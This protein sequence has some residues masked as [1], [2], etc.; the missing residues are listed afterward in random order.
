MMRIIRTFRRGATCGMHLRCSCHLGFNC[1]VPDVGEVHFGVTGVVSCL[2]YTCLWLRQTAG[3][4]ISIA[5]ALRENETAQ[6]N[7]S[8]EQSN[9]LQTKQLVLVSEHRLRFG[10][11]ASST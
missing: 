10:L 6:N 5:A 4:A 8:P 11:A 1:V 9:A 3:A 2:G 7:E